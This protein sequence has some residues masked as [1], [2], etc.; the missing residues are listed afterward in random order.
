[1][2]DN[3]VGRGVIFETIPTFAYTFGRHKISFGV[4]LVFADPYVSITFPT[5]WTYRF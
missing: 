2:Q 5:V 3:F 1:M 4:D